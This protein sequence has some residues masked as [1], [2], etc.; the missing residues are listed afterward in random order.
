MGR[1]R[2]Y[3]EVDGRLL[4]GRRL[5]F[6]DAGV[7]GWDSVQGHAAS[8]WCASAAGR[9]AMAGVGHGGAGAARLLPRAPTGCAR[10]RQQREEIRSDRLGPHGSERKGG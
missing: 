3:R 5:G 7:G 2:S 1:R 6:G 10:E 4:V 9:A 8:I